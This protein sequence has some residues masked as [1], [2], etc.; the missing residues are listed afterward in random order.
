MEKER[1]LVIGAGNIAAEYCKIVSAM[2]FEPVLVGRAPEKTIALA[3]ELNIAEYYSGG[4]DELSADFNFPTKAIVAT[5][6][7]T[8]YY[9][10]VSLLNRNVTNILVEKPAFLHQE[11]GEFLRELTNEKSA[12]LFV[13]YNRRSYASTRTALRIIKEDGGVSSVHFDFTEAISRIDPKKYAKNALQSWVLSNSTH[14]ID[15]AFLFTGIPKRLDGQVTGNAVEWHPSGSIFTG[16]GISV[17]RIP[18]TYHANW[19]SAGRWGIEIH[20]PKRKLILRPMEELSEQKWG[21]FE[22]EKITLNR[23]KEELYKPGFYLQVKDFLYNHDTIL[24]NIN[25]L[26]N[27][28]YWFSKIAGYSK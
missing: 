28:H 11:E 22:I 9:V 24:C 14:V 26:V 20:T 1:V 25:E 17:K 16:N 5:S 18:F 8:L 23:E 2:G 19:G 15:T 13:A 10:T 27:L 4:V 12:N 7:D 6:I 21:S 3:N